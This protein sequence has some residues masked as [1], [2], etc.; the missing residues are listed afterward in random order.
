[1][2]KSTT[3]AS[4]PLNAESNMIRAAVPVAT[5]ST[6]I[7]EIRFITCTRFFENR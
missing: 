4:K 6:E 5:P 2:Y 3:Q 7:A 1:L